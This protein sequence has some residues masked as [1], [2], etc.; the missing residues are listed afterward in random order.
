MA[1]S[2]DDQPVND[3]VPEGAVTTSDEAKAQA[4]KAVELG[5]NNVN[6]EGEHVDG[7]KPDESEKPRPVVNRPTVP[8]SVDESDVV[9]GVPKLKDEKGFKYFVNRN[10]AGASIMVG[11]KAV[12]EI[13]VVRFTPYYDTWKGDQVRVGYLKT[14]NKR[15]IELCQEDP[16]CEEISFSDYRL[17]LEGDGKRNQ[18]LGRAP[19]P[20]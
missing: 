14:D 7:R 12:N 4:E 10:N 15:A 17:A 13:D 1:N 16:N 2:K 5:E 6:A 11:E 9:N 3:V 19:L 18:P 8:D 20:N